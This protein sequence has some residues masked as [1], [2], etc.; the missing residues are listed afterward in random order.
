MGHVRRR[1]GELHRRRKQEEARG[2]SEAVEVAHQHSVKI[3]PQGW[4]EAEHTNRNAQ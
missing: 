4:R 1:V 2:R 3:T